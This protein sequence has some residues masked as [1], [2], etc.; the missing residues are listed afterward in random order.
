MSS[1]L[2]DRGDARLHP[3]VAVA[4]PVLAADH[5]PARCRARPAW[6]RSAASALQRVRGVASQSPRDTSSWRSSTMPADWPASAPST[7]LAGAAHLGH[8]GAARRSGTPAPRR[9]RARAPWAMRPQSVRGWWPVPVGASRAVARTYCTGSSSAPS[10]RSCAVGQALQQ[11]QQ[12]RAV[13]PRRRR[14]AAVTLS[15]RSAEIGTMPATSMPAAAAKARSA[16]RDGGE[17]RRRVGHRVELV[18]REDDARHAQ[19]VRQQR[20]A[21]RLRQQRQPALGQVELGDVD[22]HHGGVAAGGG[23]HH[24]ARV[25]LVA[26]RVGDDELA[27]AAWRSSGRPR[28]S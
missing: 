25:L 24:V 6:P 18:D 13:V 15:P 16:S 23:G 9:R 27:R 11:L 26:G 19:Q 21:A 20:V 4:H 10:V 17:G 2:L 8:G 12:R 14:A 28:R 22:Q 7:A 5:A 1:R 3:A